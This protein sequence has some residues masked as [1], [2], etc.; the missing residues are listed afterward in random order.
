MNST[1]CI[2]AVTL[3]YL[4]QNFKWS[5]LCWST[6]LLKQGFLLNMPFLWQ[7]FNTV[8]KLNEHQMKDDVLGFLLSI[9]LILINQ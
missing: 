3:L 5:S 2:L 4:I 1:N 9:S 7:C 6:Y 8:S